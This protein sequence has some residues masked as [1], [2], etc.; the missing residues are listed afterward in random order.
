MLTVKQLLVIAPAKGLI[1]RM[2]LVLSNDVHGPELSTVIESD[3]VLI[4]AFICI[5]CADAEREAS[6]S[7]PVKIEK[8]DTRSVAPDICFI[9]FNFGLLSPPQLGFVARLVLSHLRY[10]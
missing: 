9:V 4:A 6:A 5:S 8:A 10:R 7:S 1:V 2:L 3:P